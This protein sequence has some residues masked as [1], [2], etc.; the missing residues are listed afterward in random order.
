MFTS[1]LTKCQE[2]LE[3]ANHHFD[4]QQY[5][6]ALDI[7]NY[8]LAVDNDQIRL[9]QY[10]VHFNCALCCY[11]LLDFDEALLHVN[12]VL[13]QRPKDLN[14]LLLRSSIH[15]E[16]D[17]LESAKVDIQQCWAQS[18]SPLVCCHL[19][20][21]NLLVNS[22]TTAISNLMRFFPFLR[23][24]SA[25]VHSFSSLLSHFDFTSISDSPQL[26]VNLLILTAVTLFDTDHF[27]LTI[28]V[29]V[30]LN[31][32]RFL[33]QCPEASA[34]TRISNLLL[35]LS[36]VSLNDHSQAARYFSLSLE[37]NH[38]PSLFSK[39]IDASDA[40][41]LKHRGKSYRRLGNFAKSCLDLENGVSMDFGASSRPASAYTLSNRSQSMSL[42][43]SFSARPTLSSTT[44]RSVP[45]DDLSAKLSFVHSLN[46]KDLIT[47]A[48][49]FQLL[50]AIRYNDQVF[51]SA[52]IEL[53][54]D[55]ELFVEFF[56]LS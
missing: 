15:I 47:P 13:Y 35:A 18:Q 31:S 56:F 36:Y 52:F 20:Y 25:P 32:R 29:L 16:V 19:V 9:C 45:L 21:Y 50:S 55:P 38:D 53:Q 37:Y 27:L 30:F 11:R 10:S 40:S 49:R 41:I 28:H 4:N 14:S 22:P 42:T 17:N 1:Q 8:L 44:C 48:Q 23:S 54:D 7:Y 12:L 26:L 43:R 34:Y 6:K 51:N 33:S 24:L 3:T 46:D 5:S 2:L 39:L